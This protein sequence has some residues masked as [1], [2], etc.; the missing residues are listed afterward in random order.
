MSK[1]V[2]TLTSD[3]GD[4]FAV[5]QIELVIHSINPDIKFIEGENAVTPYSITEGAFILS[6]YYG[7]APAGSIHLGVVDPGV[8]SERFGIIIRSK[9]YW[10]VGPDNGLLYPAAAVD[11]IVEAY[12]INESVAGSISNTFHGRD[13]FAKVAAWI[14]NGKTITEFA[15][16]YEP[17][18]LVQHEFKQNQIVHI[19]PY[20]NIKLHARFDSF[21]YGDKVRIKYNDREHNATFSKT[22]ADVPVGELLLY[23]GSHQTLELAINQM[24]AAEYL[25]SSI[26][27][28]VDL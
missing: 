7:F 28:L 11:G 14:S 16:F 10:F 15:T 8:G 18:K 1:P 5:S 2:I 9:N 26:G 4:R 21:R 22:F 20:G 17:K 23:R 3:F 27:D 6:K 13:V 12:R 19:D 24:S 25:G